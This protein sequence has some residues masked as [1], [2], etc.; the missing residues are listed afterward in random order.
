VKLTEADEK[1]R[2][3]GNNGGGS[4]TA[5]ETAAATGDGTGVAGSCCSKNG[6]VVT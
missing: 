1:P 2:D 6:G 3:A 4:V 5:E